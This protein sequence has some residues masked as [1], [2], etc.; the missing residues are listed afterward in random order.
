MNYCPECGSPT[1]C[2]DVVSD[3]PTDH[4]KYEC[5]EGHKWEETVDK[6]GKLL[7]IAEDTEED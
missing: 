5:P 3:V 4:F 6:S 7:H 2:V 1:Y